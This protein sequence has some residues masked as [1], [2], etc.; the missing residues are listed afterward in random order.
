MEFFNHIHCKYTG[1][2]GFVTLYNDYLKYQYMIQDK[3]KKK[4]EIVYFFEK[5]GLDAA[6]SAFKVSKS[7][8]YQ[9]RNTLERTGGKLES[10]N[11]LSKAPHH[12]RGSKVEQRIKDFIQ[13]F[14]QEHPRTGKEKIKP[15]LDEFCQK[16]GIAIISESTIGRVIKELKEK[17]KI[18]RKFKVSING[19]TGTVRIKEPKPW[20]KKLRRKGYQPES[21]G[22]L[23]QLDSVVKFIYGL[24]R[25]IITAIDLKSEFAFAQA[26]KNLSSQ[27]AQDFFKKLESVSPFPILRTQTDNGSEFKLRF[28]DYL[29]KRNILHFFNYPRRPQQNAQIESFNRTIQEDFVNW[30]QALLANDIDKF[31]HK[32]TEWLLWYNT[33]RPHSSLNKQSPVQYLIENLG[34]SRM[35]WTYAPAKLDTNQHNHALNFRRKPYLTL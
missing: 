13:T 35:L 27:A 9:W 8:I 15:E 24:K 30:H 2:R 17:G 28:G 18:P 20:R 22:D 12:P 11:E 14:R 19:K 23:L 21:P 7:S 4:A 10:L 16:E 29:E 5:Y 31:N 34:F 32:L 1:V 33:K 3:S 6:V 25:Y 26:Y